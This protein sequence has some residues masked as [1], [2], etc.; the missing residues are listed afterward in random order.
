MPSW[1]VIGPTVL[2]TGANRGIDL[3]LVKQLVACP[4]VKTIFAGCRDPGAA[5][6]LNALQQKH[7]V[8]KPLRIDVQCDDSIKAAFAEV[9]GILEPSGHRGLNLLINNSGVLDKTGACV[10]ELN[11]QTYSHLFDVNTVGLAITSAVFLPLLKK[12]AANGEPARI[13]NISDGFGSSENVPKFINHPVY[14]VT[15]GMSKAAVNHYT[16]ALAAVEKDIVVAAMCPGWVQ[17]DMGGANAALT[18]EK[19]TSAILKT[20][21]GLKPED[22][23]RFIDR[24]GKTIPY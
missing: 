21:S 18:V 13:L 7:P 4:S 20:T 23:G 10:A 11:R 22:S 24:N 16:K 9:A 6:E 8:V 15:Y 14:K 1:T 5:A 17:T 12:A 2:I 19:S 3:G